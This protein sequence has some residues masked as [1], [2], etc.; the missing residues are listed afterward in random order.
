MDHQVIERNIC[1]FSFA[2]D[3]KQ[4]LMDNDFD[5]EYPQLIFLNVYTYK[6]EKN[7]PNLKKR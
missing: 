5:T 7:V 4:I 6:Y 2:M 1:N 3:R